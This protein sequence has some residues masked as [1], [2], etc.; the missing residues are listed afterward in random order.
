MLPLKNKILSEINAKGPLTIGRYMEMALFDEE[1]GYY[2]RKNPIGQQGA[3]TT[4]PEISQ[5]FG[6]LIGLFF[7]Q[8]WIDC[9][10]NKSFSLVE[11]G[12]GKGTLMADLLRSSGIVPGFLDAGSLYL[13]ERS[14]SLK[15]EQRKRLARFQPTWIDTVA[16]LEPQPVFALANE[17]FDALPIRQFVRGARYWKE[18][19]VGKMANELRFLFS[20]EINFSPLATRLNDTREGDIVEF[21]PDAQRIVGTIVDKIK[22]YGG[23]LL[24]IDYGEGYS[25]GDT[26]QALENNSFANPL[27]NPGHADLTSHVDFGALVK[28]LKGISVSPL[29]GQGEVSDKSGHHGKGRCSGHQTYRH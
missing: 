13:L 21:R 14:T 1:H 28:D 18:R 22:Q 27:D 20:G 24:I 23:M 2:N 17:F 10:Q 15:T 4:A 11:L 12:P 6:E 19:L 9:G 29:V 7:A 8:Y 5:V 25:L 3:F 26:F 16:D